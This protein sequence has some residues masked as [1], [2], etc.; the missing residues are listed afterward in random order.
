M[1]PLPDFATDL[2]AIQPWHEPVENSQSRRFSTLEKLP[3]L[4][5]IVGHNHL[6]PSL[7]QGRL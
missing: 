7:D 4:G 6:M 3:R 1:V 5:P 2:D